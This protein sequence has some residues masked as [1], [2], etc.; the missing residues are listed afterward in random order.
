MISGCKTYMIDRPVKYE[1][2]F[3]EKHMR[4]F[5]RLGMALFAIGTALGFWFLNTLSFGHH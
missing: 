3:H 2:T 4:F 5:T 1:L